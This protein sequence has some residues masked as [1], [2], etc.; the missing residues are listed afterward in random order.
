MDNNSTQNYSLAMHD[1]VKTFGPVTALSGVSFSARPGTV[2]ALCGENGAGKSTLMKVLSGIHAPDSGTIELFGEKV[3]L[4]SPKDSLDRGISMLYQELD[5]A[6]DLTVTDNIFLGREIMK[7]GRMDAKAMRERAAQIIKENHFDLDPDALISTLSTGDCQLVELLKA[8]ERNAKIIVMDEPTSSLSEKEADQLF[9]IVKDL[10]KRGLTIIYI[11]H[12]LEEVM[13]LADDISI[14]RDGAVVSSGPLSDYDV[15]R[16]V[17][18]MVGRELSDFYPPRSVEIGDVCFEAKG[19][20]SDE[21]I[22]DIS[23]QVHRGEVVGMAGLVGAGRTE[24]ARAIF[25]LQPLTAGQIFLNGKELHIKTPADAIDGRNAYLPEDRK[26]CGL[27]VGLP[28]RDNIMLPNYAATGMKWFLNFG[29]EQ[30]LMDEYGGKVKLKWASPY[31]EASSLSGGN[32]Q[33]LLVARWLLA[34]PDFII[35]DEPTRGIDIGAKKEIYTLINELAAAGK[36]VLV[37]SSELPELFG[38]CD[39]L[40]VFRRKRLAAQLET[41]KT[42]QEEVMHFAVC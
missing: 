34:N 17:H 6:G 40:L 37:I 10:R 42:T 27:C 5:L 1:I 16:I 2:H 39:R 8:L 28:C 14:L 7:F 35:F 24:T 23:F 19:L 30:K 18:E 4:A 25:G 38:I 9:S 12:R 22:A 31:D 36:G 13:D 3:V 20:A 26:R 11:S 29:K 41:A 32:Q 21:G 33:K 15:P